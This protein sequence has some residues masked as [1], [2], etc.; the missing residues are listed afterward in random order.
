MPTKIAINGFGRI[1]RCIVRALAERNIKDLELVAINDLTDAKTLAH[2]YNYDSVHGR[3]R[4]PGEARRGRHRLRRRAH[5]DHRREGPGEAPVEGAR[6]RHRARVHGPLHGQGQGGRAPRRRA[7]RRSSSARPPRATTRRSSSAST[8]EVYDAAKHTV[9]SCGSC[10]TNCLAPVAKVLL[11]VVRH[12]A[13]P[14]DDDPLV[15]Q[16]PGRPRHPAPQGRPA[17]RAR[18]GGQHDP[19]VDRRRQGAVRGHPRAQGQVRRPVDP[20]A[21]RST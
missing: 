2:L 1:G 17:A 8:R 4:A 14:D 11:D 12:R 3:A 7:P 20:R 9:I 19:V 18:G 16:R 21:R 10:T 6:R 13:R 5:Q 15:H